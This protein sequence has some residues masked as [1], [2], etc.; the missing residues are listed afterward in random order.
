MSCYRV[1]LHS[2]DFAKRFSLQQIPP[3]LSADVLVFEFEG[4]G[5]GRRGLI[6]HRGIM[7]AFFVV[8]YL[9]PR[10]LRRIRGDGSVSVDEI[11]GGRGK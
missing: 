1:S 8:P 2:T 9:S 3:H 11:A 5:G 4:S 6:S 7:N 10:C